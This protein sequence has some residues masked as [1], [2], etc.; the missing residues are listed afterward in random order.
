MTRNSWLA[1][2]GSL[3]FL[4][5]YHLLLRLS[6]FVTPYTSPVHQSL[7]KWDR[8]V[9]LIKQRRRE[10]RESGWGELA[11]HPS[12]LALYVAII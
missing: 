5:C 8:P 10:Q 2:L 3:V 7:I 4:D 6:T 12:S 11:K 9:Q 1:T